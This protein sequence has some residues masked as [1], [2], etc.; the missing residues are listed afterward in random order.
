VLEALQSFLEQAE[1]V[2]GAA[3]LGFLFVSLMTF[4]SVQDTLSRIFRVLTPPSLWRRLLAFALL[5]FWG[6]LLIGSVY[7][8][9]LVLGQSS[10]TLGELLRAS[11]LIATLPALATLIGLGMLFWRASLGRIKL[12]HAFAG[13]LLATLGL[14]LLKV[15]FRVYAMEF[16]EV[17]R[18]VYGTLAIA[19]FF[20]VSVQIGWVILLAGAEVA[21][22]LG[23]PAAPDRRPWAGTRP[24]PWTAIAVLTLMAGRFDSRRPALH[25]V[26]AAEHFGLDGARLRFLL[27]PLVDREWIEPPLAPHHGYRLI[28]P[29]DRIRMAEL[30]APYA[31]VQADRSGLAALPPS[32]AALPAQ[33]E[34]AWAAGLDELTLADLLRPAPAAPPAAPASS[35]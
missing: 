22:C 30:L 28:V 25:E 12:R 5:F 21:A 29:P 16:T 2:S 13:S 10:S 20:L 26:E 31:P 14:E 11:T 9:L 33:L 27:A 19:L 24:D 17:Q 7:G 15:G 35:A 18:A 3:L 1:Y 6:P 4:L 32:L 8:G 23:L 34:R